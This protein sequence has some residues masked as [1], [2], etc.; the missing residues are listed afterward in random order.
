MYVTRGRESEM[1]NVAAEGNNNKT[2]MTFQQVHDRLSHMSDATIRET[3][4]DLVCA[5]RKCKHFLAL[6][7]LQE[8][9]SRRT[10]NE[11]K[12]RNKRLGNDELT[13]TL[14]QFENDKECPSHP[15]PTGESSLWINASKSNS[16]SFSRPKTQWLSQHVSN[17]TNGS[18]QTLVLLT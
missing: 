18:N 2:T 16:P 1:G 9:P 14:Q 12:Q 8:R 13:L 4:N 10:S 6:L 5:S 15:N 17:C 7:A 3:A 11:P